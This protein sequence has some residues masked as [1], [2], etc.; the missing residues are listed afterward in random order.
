MMVDADTLLEIDREVLVM[1]P[2]IAKLSNRNETT[3]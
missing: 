3:P 1:Q 2:L